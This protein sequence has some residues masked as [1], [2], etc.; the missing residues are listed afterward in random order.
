MDTHPPF[1]ACVAAHL[2]KPLH[3]ERRKHSGVAENP[4]PQQFNHDDAL[5]TL[6]TGAFARSED[7]E[8]AGEVVNQRFKLR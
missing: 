4:R 7:V 5:C 3:N 1:N 2:R 8:S 6:G